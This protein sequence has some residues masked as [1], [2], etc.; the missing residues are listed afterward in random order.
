[1]SRTCYKYKDLHN[2]KRISG[3]DSKYFLT[4][5]WGTPYKSTGGE[6]R[7]PGVDVAPPGAEVRPQSMVV[8]PPGMEVR[9][10]GMLTRPA[11]M[12]VR[13]LLEPNKGIAMR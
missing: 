7:P 11:G 6:V 4:R 1:M 8:R 9:P 10:P 5:N 12:E 2:K 13:P 3:K